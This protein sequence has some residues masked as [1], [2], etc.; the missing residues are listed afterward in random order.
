MKIKLLCR[1]KTFLDEITQRLLDQL[2][3]LKLIRKDTETLQT[4]AAIQLSTFLF[5]NP[6]S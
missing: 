6:A 1:K 3:E 5:Q 4:S 2:T